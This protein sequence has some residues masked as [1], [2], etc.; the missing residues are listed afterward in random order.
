MK[1]FNENGLEK[2]FSFFSSLTFEVIPSGT[3]QGWVSPYD[4]HIR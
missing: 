3:T 4:D 1:T 2:L